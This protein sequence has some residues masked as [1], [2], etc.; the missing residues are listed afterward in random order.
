[1][2]RVPRAAGW[3]TLAASL[4]LAGPAS[5]LAAQTDRPEVLALD[6][7][8]NSVVPSDSLRRA[9]VH[10]ATRCRGW[11]FAPL[12][13]AGVE[14]VIQRNYL[15]PREFRLDVLRLQVYYIERG[16]REVEV[17]T[18]LVR[19][20]DGVRITFHIDEGRPVLVDSLELLLVEPIPDSSAFR[21]LP[22]REGDPLSA[23]ALDAA[24]DSVMAR[25]RDQGYA[26]ADALVNYFIPAGGYD[27]RVTLDVEAGPLARFGEIRVENNELLDDESVRRMLPFREGARYR[28]S[29][30]LDGQ[31]NLYGLDLVQSAVVEERR[32]EAPSDTVI[33]VRVSVNEGDLHRVR[34]GLGWTTADCLTSEARW[35][36]RNFYGGARRLEARA[37]LSNLLAPDLGASACPQAG[38]G[39]FARLNGQLG[40]ELVQ[41]W[42]FSPRN[43]LTAG[44]YIERQSLP[45]VFVREALG[46]SFAL[47]RSIG[48]RANLTLSYQPQLARLE[49]AEVFFCASFLACLPSD[50]AVFQAANWLAPVGL[51]VS[52]DRRNS[53]LNPSRGYLT[54]LDL[55]HASDITGSNFEYTRVLGEATAYVPF[56]TQVG[57]FRLRAGVV[58]RG[59]FEEL[60]GPGELDLVHPQKRFYAGGANSVRGFAENRLGPRVLT[61]D[62]ADLLGVPAVDGATEPAC[63]PEEIDLFG[64]DPSGVPDGEFSPRAVGGS[65]VVEGNVEVRFPLLTSA[66]QGVTFL[67]FGNVWSERGQVSLGDLEFTPGAGVRY[68]S[69]IGPIRVDVAYRFRAGQSLPVAT[70]GVRAYD[71]TRDSDSDR[72]RVRTADGGT[73]AIDWVRTD[74]LTFLFRQDPFGGNPSFLS[75]LQLHFSIGQAF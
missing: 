18:T 3:F 10:E 17:D 43:S 51:G 27:A 58:G 35:T 1:M 61:V 29:Q 60:G 23:L 12:C 65:V 72:I 13:W 34:T 24:R 37:R 39:A 59:R 32:A 16:Y 21:G 47:R 75:R 69:P 19:N 31:R 44:A 54:A 57:A 20:D 56:G 15:Q 70:S 9:I 67:D 36:S 11:V 8:G 52:R 68:F 7:E 66:L 55:E 30:V 48:Q 26:Y 38:T 62:V 64:C 73:E 42:I 40:L 5:P 6:F 63:A 53:V 74:E 33:P 28:R 45:D 2:N 22:L 50:I 41:P 49:A 25:L 46:F 14:G 4:V 71:P